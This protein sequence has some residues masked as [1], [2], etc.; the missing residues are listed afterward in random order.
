MR[1]RDIVS[2]P[3]D[4]QKDGL[5][6]AAARYNLRLSILRA[7][8]A[9]GLAA[10]VAFLVF[11]MP[12]AIDSGQQ[13]RYIRAL[14]SVQTLDANL[15]ELVLKSRLGLLSH[16]DPLVRATAE[17]DRLHHVLEPV[18]DFLLAPGQ[19]DIRR[20]IAESRR[21]LSDKERIV[22]DFKTQNAILRN[23]S[24]F[25]PVASAELIAQ[26]TALPTGGELATSLRDLR[27][28]VML[29][30][31]FPDRD[32]GAQIARRMQGVRE[33]VARASAADLED[34]TDILLTHARLILERKPRVDALVDRIVAAPTGLRAS[35][36]DAAYARHYAAALARAEVHRLV[37]FALA[38]GMVGLAAAY[39]ILRLQR[40][41]AA[42]RD[43]TEKLGLANADLERRHAEQKDLAELKSRF[44]AMTSH[45]FRT[46]L[47]VILSSSELL[48]TYGD[49][50]QPEKKRDHF[51]KIK[52]AVKGMAQM[53]EDV[54]VL[55]RAEAGKLEFAP[56]TQDVPALCA[57]LVKDLGD[58]AA[59]GREIVLA[60][61]GD[62]AGA[63][64]DPK[65]VRHILTNLL[66]NALKYSPPEKAVH[67]DAAAEGGHAAFAVRDE[68]I[69]IP[70]E[71][72]ARLFESFHR[73]RNVGQI[74][75]TGLGLAIV[76]RSVDLHGGTINV[77]SAVG[78]GTTFVVRIPMGTGA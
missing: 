46:P 24:R 34:D 64:V 59:R 38:L 49:R 18:P 16:Y 66:S 13:D 72:Q 22:E 15:N 65:L 8:L 67:F 48:E 12:H 74:A 78:E 73:A 33:V 42:L 54:L 71:D 19:A 40:S 7:L 6:R 14:R 70:E 37:L 56:S 39:I 29:F 23:S 47:S 4:A 1:L 17:L 21:A 9:A 27:S 10:C 20:R 25:F 55:G 32:L 61:R 76:K 69:G 44:V 35:A 3:Y 51:R 11:V 41:G 30:N 53:L 31:L 68:G 63:S 28:D 57:E 45:E 2:D 62:W 5:V 60:V 75:G 50:W 36:L 26:A 43:A 52:T 58:G 77:Q